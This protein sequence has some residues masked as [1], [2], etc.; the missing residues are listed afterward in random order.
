MNYQEAMA[1]LYDKLPM[2]QRVGAKA[3]KKDLT[4]TQDLLA[5]LGNPQQRFP[6]LHIAG[7]NGKGS[8]THMLAAIAI[9][10]GYRVGY[11]TS[12][13]LLDFRERIRLNGQKIPQETI[14]GFVTA[15]QAKIEEIQ[16]SFFEATV[17]MA[18]SYFAEE[19]VDLAVIETGLG[20]RLDSTNVLQPEV[21]TITNVGYDHQAMLGNTL[22]EIAGEKA[23]IIKENIPAVIG[24]SHPE[25]RQVFNEKALQVGTT[26]TFADKQWQYEVRNN[27]PELQLTVAPLHGKMPETYI[28]DLPG[29]YQIPNLLATLETIYQLNRRVYL[30]SK[31]WD[32]SNEAVRKGL[33]NI[34]GLTG[35]RGRWEQ[36]NSEPLVICDIAH[37]PDAIRWHRQQL[38]HYD[39]QNLHLVFGMT[40]EKELEPIL[41]SLPAEAIYHFCHPDLPRGRPGEELR[42]QAKGFDLEGTASSSVSEALDHAINHAAGTDDLILVT[43][44]A[45]VVAEAL[46]YFEPSDAAVSE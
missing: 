24:E 19:Q 31:S 25:T 9:E 18:L 22:A 20:G 41:Q 13:H 26:L 11:Y 44:S 38:S 43:G 42:K 2:F 46:A 40:Q 16:P 8:V 4:N 1:Y 35:L 33:S 34:R 37:N 7:T 32:I 27:T 29:F 6:S 28:C 39:Y 10:A 21:T 17:S 30:S 23:G 12:P 3:V 36:L 15:N 5:H 45:F 14:A